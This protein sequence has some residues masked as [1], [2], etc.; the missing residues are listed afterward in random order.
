M[1]TLANVQ[2]SDIK[3]NDKYTVNKYTWTGF[4]LTADTTSTNIFVKAT[5]NKTEKAYNLDVIKTNLIPE[6]TMYP[7][8][9]DN[10]N[11]GYKATY[12][13]ATGKFTA[14]VAPGTPGQIKIDKDGYYV[15]YGY[16]PNDGSE[17][18]ANKAKLYADND[19][20]YHMVTM[21]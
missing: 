16:I 19:E 7:A 3:D 15:R 2:I 17:T 20:Q 10:Y 1:K 14:R 12:D 5:D 18:Y 8:T 6:V 21:V 4:K 13:S 11:N 9:V